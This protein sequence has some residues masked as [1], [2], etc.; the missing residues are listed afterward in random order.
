MMSIVP[1]PSTVFTLVMKLTNVPHDPAFY[2]SMTGLRNDFIYGWEIGLRR[3]P[4]VF[5]LVAYEWEFCGPMGGVIRDASLLARMWGQS[6]R[7]K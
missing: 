2:S 3:I 4:V 6:G 7:L 5:F 1:L